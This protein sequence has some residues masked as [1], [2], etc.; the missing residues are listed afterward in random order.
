[1]PN[2]H[3]TAHE[4]KSHVDWEYKVGDKYCCKTRVYSARH[5]AD[6]MV[7]LGQLGP[8]CQSIEMEQSGFN[9]EQNHN[10]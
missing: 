1:M 9:M 6:I 4:N 5:R 7:I 8:S 10:V 2:D 3:N